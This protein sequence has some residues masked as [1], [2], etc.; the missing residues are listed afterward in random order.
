[1]SRAADAAAPDEAAAADRADGEAQDHDDDDE[2]DEETEAAAAMEAAALF[3]ATAAPQ[4]PIAEFDEH[5]GVKG[6]A[7]M[8]QTYGN[9]GGAGWGPSD[10]RRRMLGAWVEDTKAKQTMSLSEYERSPPA[11]APG[12]GQ[13]CRLPVLPAEAGTD[14]EMCVAFWTAILEACPWWH[15]DADFDFAIPVHREFGRRWF[16]LWRGA[17]PGGMRPWMPHH[18]FSFWRM[19]WVLRLKGHGDLADALDVYDMDCK[20]QGLLDWPVA[21]EEAQCG[22]CD[23]TAS[24][25]ADAKTAAAF[26]AASVAAPATVVD[27]DE[28]Q[29]GPVVSLLDGGAVLVTEETIKRPKT[30]I[31]PDHV[32]GIPVLH[33]LHCNRCN[34]QLSPT[35]DKSGDRAGTVTRA[36]TAAFSVASVTSTTPAGPPN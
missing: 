28:T 32:K 16:E 27:D 18:E 3:Q 9:D 11:D 13:P 24:L 5:G 6:S 22:H 17:V 15:T 2:S 21:L 33:G 1:M 7:F 19:V 14:M 8:L 10:C 25:L 30:V 29:L 20:E 12:F 26:A 31:V 23:S 34:R 4:G 36:V 35:Y